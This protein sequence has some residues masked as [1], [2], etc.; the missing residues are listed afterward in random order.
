MRT[1]ARRLV[2]LFRA[3]RLALHIGYGLTLAI[4]YP[5]LALPIRQ[6]IL[7]S[8]SAGLLDIFNVRI[9]VAEG[10]PLH[11]LRHG[12]IV[13]NHISWLD[14]FVLN[15]VV[16]M[17]F[18]AKSEVRRWPVIGWLCARAQTLFIELGHQKE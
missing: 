3:A 9:Q 17:R 2:A 13:T 5:W 7:Q 1:F 10:D 8:W 4:A 16:P 14:V 15:A 12:L 6:R 18:V 11:A